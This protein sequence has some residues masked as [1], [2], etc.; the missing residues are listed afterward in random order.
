MVDEKIQIAE[1]NSLQKERET[2][3]LSKEK[4]QNSSPKRK[5]KKQAKAPTSQPGTNKRTPPEQNNKKKTNKQTKKLQ[6][7]KH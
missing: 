6:R 4:V 7:I 5:P 1:G 3:N 2:P